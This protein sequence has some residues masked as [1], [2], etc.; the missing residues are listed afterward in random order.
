M[1]AHARIKII[2]LWPISSLPPFPHPASIEGETHAWS[3]VRA[4]CSRVLMKALRALLSA[5][6]HEP[7]ASRTRLQRSRCRSP[8][9]SDLISN[10]WRQTSFPPAGVCAPGGRSL[11]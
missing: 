6:F 1:G 2:I 7:S 11:F 4:W 5:K 3:A 9:A 8:V 10:T